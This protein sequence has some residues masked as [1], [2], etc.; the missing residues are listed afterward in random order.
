MLSRGRGN[1]PFAVPP[2]WAPAG[3]IDNAHIE[4]AKLVWNARS[5][6]YYIHMSIEIDDCNFEA[7]ETVV[8][9]DSGD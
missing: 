8:A 4:L 9:I 1:K 2:S 7:N 6:R 3:W 5:K